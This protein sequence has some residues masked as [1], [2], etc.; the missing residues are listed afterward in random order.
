MTMLPITNLKNGLFQRTCS[1]EAL[2]VFVPASRVREIG[3]VRA[4]ALQSIEGGN[5]SLARNKSGRK[6]KCPN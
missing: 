4:A 3:L 1:F 5:I 6:M 2:D